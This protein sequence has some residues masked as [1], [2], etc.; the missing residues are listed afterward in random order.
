MCKISINGLIWI[1]VD[2][3]SIQSLH[4]FHA[5]NFASY[6]SSADF[7]QNEPLSRNIFRNIMRVS[8]SYEEHFV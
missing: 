2:S 4:H 5:E 8:I 1:I 3:F 7:F 6:L